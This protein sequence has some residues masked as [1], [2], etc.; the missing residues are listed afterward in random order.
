VLLVDPAAQYF[1]SMKIGERAE[2][3]EIS[4][5]FFGNERIIHPAVLWDDGEG[6][7]L[8]DTGLPGQ[9]PLIRQKLSGLGLGLKDIRRILL[10]HQDIDHIGSAQALVEASGARV[11]AH[12]ADAPYIS[13]ERKLLKLDV[14]RLEARLAALPESER[15][16][17]RRLIDP[18]PSVRVDQILKGG[19]ELPFHGGVLVIHTPGHT[20]GHVCYY[21]RSQRLLIA[22][23]ALRVDGGALMG[24]SPT[25]TPDMAK[26]LASLAA[27]RKL[28]IEGVLCYHGGFFR[29]NPAG[30]L[31]ELA[32]EGVLQR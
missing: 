8:I 2:A 32:Q 15:E 10:T 30:R 25:A 24:P 19:E 13:G 14:P 23:D 31:R 9:A 28:P 7:T 17:A 6:A 12:E 21:L 3:L 16:Q 20:P 29:G 22:G 4:M 26:A 5:G 18:L 27:L 11:L 1:F